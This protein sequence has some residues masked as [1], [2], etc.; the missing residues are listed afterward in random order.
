MIVGKETFVMSGIEERAMRTLMRIQRA[1]YDAV[2]EK[3]DTQGGQVK[4]E[5]VGVKFKDEGVYVVTRLRAINP[6]FKLA[7]KTDKTLVL[8]PSDC[9]VFLGKV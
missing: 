4:H 8:R 1:A 9:A 5:P 6:K 3:C 7:Q 2:G